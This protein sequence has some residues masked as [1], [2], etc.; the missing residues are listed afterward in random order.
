MAGKKVWLSW[1]TDDDP[2][3][4]AA[5]VAALGR[6]G[7]DVEGAPWTDD[8]EKMAWLPLADRLSDP[9]YDA[10]WMVGG[11]RE[12]FAVSSKRYGLSMALTVVCAAKNPPPMVML[13]GTDGALDSGSLPTLVRARSRPLDASVAGWAEKALVATVS[14]PPAW[15]EPFRLNVIADPYAGQWFEVGSTGGAWEGVMF[16]VTGE[17]K[18]DLHAVGPAGKLPE[19]TVLECA[20]EGIVADIGDREFT[21]NAVQNKLAPDESYFV[22]VTGNP[23]CVVIGQHPDVDADVSVVRLG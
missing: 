9:G 12:D 5:A 15:G 11:R 10:I 20:L 21:A 17:G 2:E 4:P 6:A 14:K 8:L 16:G 18:I 3:G 22:K 7:F 23:E 13:V 19:K 1:L